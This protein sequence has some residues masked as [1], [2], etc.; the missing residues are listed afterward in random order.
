MP[1]S[2]GG[3]SKVLYGGTVHHDLFQ[4]IFNLIS[5][6]KAVAAEAHDGELEIYMLADVSSEMEK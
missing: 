1:I 2:W 6:R 3:W 5:S 4:A